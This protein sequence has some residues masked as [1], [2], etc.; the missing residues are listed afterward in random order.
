[1]TGSGDSAKKSP[2]WPKPDYS[3]CAF[4]DDFPQKV[5]YAVGFWTAQ[6][7]TVCGG[8]G[9]EDKCFLYEKYQ[10]KTW[11]NM[12]TE[13]RYASALQ[14]NS[15]HTLIIGGK[16][17]NEKRLQT[18]ELIS[19][20]GSKEGNTFPVTISAH[21]SFHINATHGMVTA[22]VQN[23]KNS[24]ATWY[25]NMTSTTFVR[26]PPMT[27][28]RV[29]HGCSIVQLGSKSYGVV[30]GGYYD[31]KLLDSTEMINLD[32]ESPTWIDGMQDKSKIVYF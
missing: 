16:D 1:M 15:S 30:S 27:T 18:T 28:R 29:A 11:T 13:R 24:S 6:G 9:G 12:E 19:S 32:Q 2:L 25:V 21:C 5:S 8:L 31:R 23:G 14:I 3:Q 22:G 10:W 20:S 17:E 26:G 4:A 7:P